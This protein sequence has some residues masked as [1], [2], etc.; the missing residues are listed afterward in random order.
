MNEDTSAGSSFLSKSAAN[1]VI[2]ESWWGWWLPSRC[3]A[4]FCNEIVQAE[5]K[6]SVRI[7]V[8]YWLINVLQDFFAA[9][10]SYEYE[11][12]VLKRE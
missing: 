2:S 7:W 4:E 3:Q 8:D 11:D 9:E 12:F 1:A 5:D 6:W 10:S